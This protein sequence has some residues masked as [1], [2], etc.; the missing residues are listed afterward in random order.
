MKLFYFNVSSLPFSIAFGPRSAAFSAAIPYSYV[1][2]GHEFENVSK[3]ISL[4]DAF[5][6]LVVIL[7]SRRL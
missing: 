2:K 6:T 3:L 4:D 7:P 5:T 1:K